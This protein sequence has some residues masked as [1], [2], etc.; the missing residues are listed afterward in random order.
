MTRR[1]DLQRHMESLADIRKIIRSMQSLAYIQ[2]RKLGRRLE[3][4][5]QRLLAV[6]RAAGDFLA[7]RPGLPA[8]RRAPAVLIVIGS[9]RGFC[10]DFNETLVDHLY[11]PDYAGR[12]PGPVVIGVGRRLCDLLQN[13][14]RGLYP[15]AGADV[16]EELDR[17]LGDL[18]AA[19]QALRE[20]EGPLRLDLLCH[21]AEDPVP[22]TK[23]LFPPFGDLPRRRPGGAPPL[24][25]LPPEE[26]LTG[27]MEHYLLAAL[28]Q[29]LHT[30]LMAENRRRV[31]QLEA[32][33]RHLDE[34]LA[35]LERK[36][37]QLRQ[38]E[39]IEEIEVILL[40]ASG[41]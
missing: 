22:S 24:L 32:A 30:A 14:A 21:G 4:Q 41:P 16:P 28:H 19:T 25:N 29:S 26:V 3:R 13:R 1:H 36:G 2:T 38:E 8:V 31:Q 18:L 6:E 34:R 33:G 27:L 12:E 5:Q 11:G 15:I 39:I 17:V 35:A 7:F 23:T 10:G 40:G 20:R 9:E 37:R